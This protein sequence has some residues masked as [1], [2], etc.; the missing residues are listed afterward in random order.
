MFSHASE[1]PFTRKR[2]PAL[3]AAFACQQIQPGGIVQS[4]IWRSSSTLQ[5]VFQISQEL[6]GRR[7]PR[8]LQGGEEPLSRR[9][10]KANIVG[11]PCRSHWLAARHAGAAALH[12]NRYADALRV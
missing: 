10:E 7:Q 2:T 4:W 1:Q 8:I 6:V 9:R 12:R 3:S 5:T 11:L